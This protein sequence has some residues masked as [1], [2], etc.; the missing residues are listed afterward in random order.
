MERR[1]NEGIMVVIDVQLESVFN[2]F[3]SFLFFSLFPLYLAGAKEGTDI[4]KVSIRSFP[5]DTRGWDIF[6]K[7]EVS[8]RRRALSW[9]A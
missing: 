3:F 7:R 5:F 8:T 2:F 4:D 9:S 6:N 1:D